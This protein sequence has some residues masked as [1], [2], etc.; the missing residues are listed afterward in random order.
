[1]NRKDEY[2]RILIVD[3]N[4]DI[5][6]IAKEYLN[7]SGN[8]VDGAPDGREA[9]EK[10]KTEVYDLIITDLNMPELSGMDLIQEVRKQNDMTEFVI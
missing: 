5:R 6:S 10:C 7:S 1:M 2:F 8:S 9:L 4:E 3:D